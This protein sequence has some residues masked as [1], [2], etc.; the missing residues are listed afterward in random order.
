MKT[1]VRVEY[2][3][4]DV[5]K[6]VACQLE[7]L[8]DLD[9]LQIAEINSIVSARIMSLSSNNC[10]TKKRPLA[11]KSFIEN[12]HSGNEYT[13]TKSKKEETTKDRLDVISQCFRQTEEYD[14]LTKPEFLSLCLSYVRE[15]FSDGDDIQ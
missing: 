12:Y 1:K 8:L 7:D 10:K 11:K 4:G 6:V 14:G 9:Q 3:L 13:L 15:H 2:F 5:I